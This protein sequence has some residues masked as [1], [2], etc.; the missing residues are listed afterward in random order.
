MRNNDLFALMVLAAAVY[1]I[2][3]RRVTTLALPGAPIIV[4]DT[5]STPPITIGNKPAP[6][7][8]A[9]HS[10]GDRRECSIRCFRAPCQCNPGDDLPI[11]E[12]GLWDPSHPDAHLLFSMQ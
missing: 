10:N 11:A 2:H 1:L 7:T 12:T 6:G 3:M 9:G 4:D 5:V 8:G